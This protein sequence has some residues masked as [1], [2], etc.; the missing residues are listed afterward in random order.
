MN[1]NGRVYEVLRGENGED[2]FLAEDGVTVGTVRQ[3]GNCQFELVTHRDFHKIEA[4]S[5]KA[6][7]N[8]YY[9]EHYGAA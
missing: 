2:A 1:T 6:L 4:G 5:I 8:R 7:T 9:E 3:T